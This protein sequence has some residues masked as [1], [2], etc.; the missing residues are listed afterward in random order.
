MKKILVVDDSESMRKTI[1]NV[2]A[3]LDYLVIEAED[4]DEGLEVAKKHT[5][6]DIMLLDI[7][8]PNMNGLQLAKEFSLMMEFCR[9]PCIMLTTE[10][11]P[12][13]IKIAKEIGN[14]KGWI[15][16][17]FKAPRLIETLEKTVQKYR[18]KK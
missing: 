18:A 2:L 15:L 3:S 9:I 17:P 1:R 6:L 16:K 8:M 7:N 5:D 10:S 13:K 12:E 11:D 14:I 4:G